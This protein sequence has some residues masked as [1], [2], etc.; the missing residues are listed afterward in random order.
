MCTV[1]EKSVAVFLC[2]NFG[3]FLVNYAGITFEG[4]MHDA[5]C[6]AKN[7]AELFA[8]VRD[9]ERCNLEEER[10]YYLRKV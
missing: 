7:T 9:K 1:I 5:L 2:A 3:Q 6:D 8:I 4:H 10:T